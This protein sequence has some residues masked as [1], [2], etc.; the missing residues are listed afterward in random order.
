MFKKSADIL[1]RLAGKAIETLP[2]IL[3]RVA[4]AILNFLGNVVEFAA[5]HTRALIGFAAERIGVCLMQKVE[6]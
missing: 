4:G 6:N 2:A 3:G 5:E 1:K